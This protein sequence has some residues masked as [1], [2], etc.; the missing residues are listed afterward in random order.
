VT[1]SLLASLACSVHKWWRHDGDRRVPIL[2]QASRNIPVHLKIGYTRHTPQKEP[3]WWKW[4]LISGSGGIP[5]LQQTHSLL[6]QSLALSA[7]LWS[8]FQVIQWPNHAKEKEPSSFRSIVLEI[9][10][11]LNLPSAK[12]KWCDHEKNSQHL[13]SGPQT[14]IFSLF[15]KWMWNILI[16]ITATVYYYYYY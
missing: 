4:W 16:G 3:W 1:S 7:A 8:S 13:S 6:K 10:A 12:T 5:I 14:L 9:S 2:I 15:G 11:D